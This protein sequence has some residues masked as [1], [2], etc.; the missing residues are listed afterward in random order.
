MT[1]RVNLKNFTFSGSEFIDIVRD[2][3]QFANSNQSFDLSNCMLKICR[4]TIKRHVNIKFTMNEWRNLKMMLDSIGSEDMPY[5]YIWGKILKK[6]RD[7]FWNYSYW[8]YIIAGDEELLFEFV[9]YL[10]DK[11]SRTNYD[12]G[13]KVAVVV[14]LA[15]RSGFGYL[16]NDVRRYALMRFGYEGKI[17]F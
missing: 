11:L 14:R 12:L 3:I 5:K 9:K 13:S 10:C 4:R 17:N 2:E 15:W 7:S 8:V 1:C 16:K 6:L